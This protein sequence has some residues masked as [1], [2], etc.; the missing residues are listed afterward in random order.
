MAIYTRERNFNRI[1]EDLNVNTIPLK[2]IKDIT[3]LLTD[4]KELVLTKA[5]FIKS[6]SESLESLIENLGLDSVL[7]DL[8]IRVDFGKVEEDVKEQVTNLLDF[9][10]K[11]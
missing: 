10:K 4:G 1:I 6:K 7:A 11:T 8:K 5:D 2:F 3:C 9:T